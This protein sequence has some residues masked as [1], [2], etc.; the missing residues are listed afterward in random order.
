MTVGGI[1]GHSLRV[2]HVTQAARNGISESKI[3]HQTGHKS[4]AMVRRYIRIGQ[5]F[6]ENAA[7]GLESEQAQSAELGSQS[8]LE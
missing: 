7:T 4:T 6:S 8:A 1:A 5:L 3:M 2:G